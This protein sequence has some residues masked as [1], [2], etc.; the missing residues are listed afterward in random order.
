MAFS[1][2]DQFSQMP[3]KFMNM[4]PFMAATGITTRLYSDIARENLKA[5]NELM[6]CSVEQLQG[7]SNARGL[8]EVVSVQSKAINKATP[9]L[10]QH[11][12]QVLDLMMASATEYSKLYE[13]NFA[14]TTG[15]TEKTHLKEV[16]HDAKK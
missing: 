8:E 7:L 15:Q 4:E 12:Q 3:A 2:F 6:Q 16:K 11:A 5:M 1:Y 13:K 10:F 9:Q 14:K